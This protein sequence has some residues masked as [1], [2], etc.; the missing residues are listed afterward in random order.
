M[1]TANTAAD[2]QSEV[3]RLQQQIAA[4]SSG[5]LSVTQLA[6][7]QSSKAASDL[8]KVEMDVV[9]LQQL[10]LEK[11]NQIILL[12]SQTA[13]QQHQLEEQCSLLAEHAREHDEKAAKK[14]C[15]ALHDGVNG[16]GDL[17]SKTQ[18]EVILEFVFSEWL[19]ASE[20][21]FLASV[22]SEWRRRM[23]KKCYDNFKLKEIAALPKKLP[24]HVLPVATAVNAALGSS[25]RLH[26][27]LDHIK[28]TKTALKS[29]SHEFVST[30]IDVAVDPVSVLQL[31]SVRTLKQVESSKG[32]K[33]CAAAANADDVGLLKWLFDHGCPWPLSSGAPATL[34]HMTHVKCLQ[35]CATAAGKGEL[36][37]IQSLHERG[38]PWDES[39]LIKAAK[40][41]HADIVTW[42]MQHGCP[43]PLGEDHR[44]IQ[45]A[46]GAINVNYNTSLLLCTAAKCGSVPLMRWLHALGGRLNEQVCIAAAESGH[47]AALQWARKH[48]C[49]WGVE[50]CAIAAKGGH[51]AVLQWARQHG[52]CWNAQTC[53]MAAGSGDLTVLKWARMH[54]CPWDTQTCA[55]AADSGDPTVL[56]WAV[57]CGCPWDDQTAHHAAM[58]GARRS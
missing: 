58:S 42:A 14:Q 50:V 5:A 51:L 55:M 31:V 44:P 47:L 39:T 30:V 27:A 34:Q 19:S 12:Q 46:L 29:S 38:C 33:L 11:D 56:Q 23:L 16:S 24:K 3:Q 18:E 9:K 37:L 26:W 21:I 49:P 54:G 13:T 17:L 25:A 4:A 10:L 6:Q 28:L 8:T 35:L 53:A 41:G 2:L 22:N 15:V 57:R 7:A 48:G 43:W 1:D 45:R 32:S 40:Q 52:C 36:D 20:Y